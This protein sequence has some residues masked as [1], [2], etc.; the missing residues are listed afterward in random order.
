MARTRPWEVSDA[1][2]ERVRPLLPERPPHPTG[3]RPAANDREM[4]A[5][6]MYV[7]RTG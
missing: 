3:G 1:L 7:L 5:A 4:F 2:W 6:M